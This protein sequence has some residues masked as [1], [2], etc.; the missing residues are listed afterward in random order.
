MDTQ[1][2]EWFCFPYEL[3]SRKHRKLQPTF[4]K[5]LCVL[6][7]SL[8]TQSV[9]SVCNV[10]D[11]GSIS[12]SERSLGEGNGN[13][14]QYSCWRIPWTEEPLGLQSMESQR[15][16]HDWMTNT[17]SLSLMCPNITPRYIVSLL[18]LFSLLSHLIYFKC[19]IKLLEYLPYIVTCSG[20][21]KLNKLMNNNSLFLIKLM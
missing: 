4:C 5:T 20:K 16:G 3:V 1:N 13:T 11:S 6:K 12:G 10:G 7:S 18:D 2:H 14:L 8:V 21:S 9:E 17:P 19:K 15:V